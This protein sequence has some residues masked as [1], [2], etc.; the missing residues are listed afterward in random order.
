M[1]Q[2]RGVGGKRRKRDKDNLYSD[3]EDDLLK[4]TEEDQEETTKAKD[5][6]KEK[7]GEPEKKEKVQT[8]AFVCR[9]HRQSTTLTTT[10]L[11]L[12]LPPRVFSL[13]CS[14]QKRN[15]ERERVL[16]DAV[17]LDGHPVLQ[18]LVQWKEDKPHWKFNKA[19]QNKLLKVLYL[20]KHERS[21]LFFFQIIYA[22][23]KLH[24]KYWPIFLEYIAAIISETLRK[25]FLWLKRSSSCV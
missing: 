8:K 9:I 19:K 25:V 3:D 12:N 10:F 13:L 16:S 17:Y 1:V 11:L 14:M 15:A 4:D 7:A 21:N 22:T 23:H 5:Q 20:G 2:R 6:K 18:F 24:E